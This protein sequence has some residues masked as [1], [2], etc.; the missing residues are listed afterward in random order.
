MSFAY[1]SDITEPLPEKG[2][3]TAMVDP[4]CIKDFYAAGLHVWESQSRKHKLVTVT[5]SRI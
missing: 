4:N 1:G 3:V 2:P 5:A